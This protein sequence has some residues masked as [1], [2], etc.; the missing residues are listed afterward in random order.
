MNDENDEL[1]KIHEQLKEK[2]G[3]PKDKGLRRLSEKSFEIV[4]VLT[5]TT[6]K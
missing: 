4:R 2:K 1:Y 6:Y 5:S 3:R